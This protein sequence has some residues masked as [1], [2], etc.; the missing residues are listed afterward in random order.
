M[1]NE[2]KKEIWNLDS[3]MPVPDSTENGD[4]LH[5]IESTKQKVTRL[6]KKHK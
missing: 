3:I 4:Y 2:T 5:S 1:Q 6:S